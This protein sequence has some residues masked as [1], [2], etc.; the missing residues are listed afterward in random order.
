MGYT[1]YYHYPPLTPQQIQN[2]REDI[3]ALTREWD[4]PLD[5][6]DTDDY[7]SV[8]G[9]DD[10]GHENLIWPPRETH[11]DFAG[12]QFVK[13]NRKPYDAV[14]FAALLAIR[15][16]VPGTEIA[17]DDNPAG[18]YV[19]GIALYRQTFPDRTIAPPYNTDIDQP[20]SGS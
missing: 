2:V 14:I 17:T 8:N 9:I 11:D 20:G 3:L 13:T 19:Y 12:R 10:E 6:I 7:I 15:H 1:N 4:S 5:I 16:H 18:Q